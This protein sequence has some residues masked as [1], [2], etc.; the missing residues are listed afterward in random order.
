MAILDYQ[1]SIWLDALEL[2]EHQ[3]PDA[4]VLEGTWWRETATRNRLALLSNVRE[5]NFPD[6]YIGDIDGASVVYCCAYGAARAVEPAHVFAQLGTPLLIQIGTCGTLDVNAS[7]GTVVL[8]EDCAARDGVSQHYGAGEYVSTHPDWVA[9]AELLLQAQDRTV[10]R[11][12]HLTW[13][14]LFAQSNAMCNAWIDE[15]FLSIDMETATVAAVADHFNVS[16]VSLLSVWD[17]L[18]HGRTFMDPLDAQDAA[19]LARSNEVVFENIH[20]KYKTTV[21]TRSKY[22]YNNQI[23]FIGI[24]GNNDATGC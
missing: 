9:R 24:I 6:M 15:G 22:E 16:C 8:P 7:T 23:S 14:S 12:H 17:A 3:I 11:A 10:K 13:P 18:P 5:L 19:R 2:A 20:S 4:L 1:P 21:Q